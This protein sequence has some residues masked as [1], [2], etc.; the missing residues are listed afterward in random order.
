MTIGALFTIVALAFLA[1]Y[2]YIWYRDKYLPM[3]DAKN[4]IDRIEEEMK[5]WQK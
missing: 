5:K 3:R 2:G 4:E 1:W